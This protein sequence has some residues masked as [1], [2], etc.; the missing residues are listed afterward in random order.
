[1]TEVGELEVAAPDVVALLQEVTLLSALIF[2]VYP[3]L[4]ITKRP[5]LINL[6]HL[7]LLVGFT[8]GCF[9]LML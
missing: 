3:L 6:P 5:L 9:W 8:G 7:L 4:Q 1:M 2:S